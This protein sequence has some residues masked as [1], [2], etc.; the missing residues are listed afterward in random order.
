MGLQGP[1]AHTCDAW[2]RTPAVRARKHIEIFG[3]TRQKS[4]VF[5]FITQ[6]SAI[7]EVFLTELEKNN[8]MKK[9][10]MTKEDVTKK[11]NL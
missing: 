4:G 9:L 5:T 7:L 1:S 3:A 6:I 2:D 10:H 8:K 11:F